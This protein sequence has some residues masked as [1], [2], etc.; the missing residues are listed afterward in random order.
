MTD[1]IT[2]S[3]ARADRAGTDPTFELFCA[4]A[5]MATMRLATVLS[6]CV[7]YEP[8]ALIQV[9][10]ETWSE[11]GDLTDDAITAMSAWPFVN[12]TG[13]RWRID[14]DI[15]IALRDRLRLENPAE[16][17]ELHRVLAAREAREDA[18]LD[19]YGSW[20]VRGRLAFYLAAID[21]Q[22]SL[23]EFAGAFV[24]PPAFDRA[25]CRMW[26]SDLVDRQSDLLASHQ[27]EVT[28]Y[29]AFAMYSSGMARDA[30]SLIKLFDSVIG[31]E[32]EP[33]LYTAIS[34]H[35][36]G[37][38]SKPSGIDAAIDLFR[39]SVE[40][41]GDLGIR[42]NEV[43]ARNSLVWALLDTQEDLSRT[44]EIAVLNVAEAKDLGSPSMI[45]WTRRTAATVKW[46]KATDRRR[47]FPPG[48]EKL[49]D[50]L[51]EELWDVARSSREAGDVETAIYA[52]NESACIDRDVGNYEHALEALELASQI[53]LGL[54]WRPHPTQ[55]IIK[56]T[57][58][59]IGRLT[60]DQRGRA[61][62]I[63][64]ELPE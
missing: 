16:F 64:T 44:T 55:N 2:Q 43:M 27:R 62:T 39:A 36:K 57:R 31:P 7:E 15:A 58:S 13:A 4:T 6:C 53:I 26:I 24:D 12:A 38:L 42:D 54:P 61:E 17:V 20:F 8:G 30:K 3:V 45:D 32:P 11:S 14:R 5:D 10:V 52:Y 48:V 33:D 29:R 47:A 40:L 49:A 23:D 60:G 41:S 59:F 25:R 19:E 9:A 63:L 35:L 22:Q 1:V 18:E 21:G 46:M 34:M 56:T 50:E 51:T 37:V 28:F